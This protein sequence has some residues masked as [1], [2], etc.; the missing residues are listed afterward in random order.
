MDGKLSK[1][2]KIFR[3]LLFSCSSGDVTEQKMHFLAS[4]FTNPPQTHSHLWAGPPNPTLRAQTTLSVSNDRQ[5]YSNCKVFALITAK[6]PRMFPLCFWYPFFLPAF[7]RFHALML[8]SCSAAR[9]FTR[10]FDGPSDRSDLAVR[11]GTQRKGVKAPRGEAPSAI[12]LRS[13][14]AS[15]AAAEPGNCLTTKLSH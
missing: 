8:G 7:L 14:W 6:Q 13:A 12:L 3:L 1:N 15:G 11:H 5:K 4:V 9:Q 10:T 2:K